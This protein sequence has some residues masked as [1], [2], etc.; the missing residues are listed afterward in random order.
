MKEISPKTTTKV[1]RKRNRQE[2]KV[3]D[4]V[5]MEFSR[6]IWSDRK[7]ILLRQK[8]LDMIA[9]EVFHRLAERRKNRKKVS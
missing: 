8:H 6:T 2:Q 7:M 1:R 4:E 3:W 5:L 9:M